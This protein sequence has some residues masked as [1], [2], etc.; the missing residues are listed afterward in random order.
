MFGAQRIRLLR[1]D[2]W[3]SAQALAEEL[4]TMLSDEIGLE[5]KG[6]LTLLRPS[7]YTGPMI[8]F[9]GTEDDLPFIQFKR[10]GTVLGELNFTKEALELADKDGKNE[11]R[12]AKVNTLSTFTSGT[13][14]VPGKIISGIGDTYTVDLYPNGKNGSVGERVTVIQLQ[15]DSAETIPADTWVSVMKTG[16]TYSMQVPVWL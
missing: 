5:H 12:V 8:T 3:P 4:Y 7:G 1:E 13:Q 9:N 10:K 16:S 2:P 15:I 6:P 11:V 14:T